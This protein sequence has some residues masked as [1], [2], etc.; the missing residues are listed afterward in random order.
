MG[1]ARVLRGVLGIIELQEDAAPDLDARG[2]ATPCR[3]LLARNFERS[4]DNRT[5]VT[6]RSSVL[7]TIYLCR[8][9][10]DLYGNKV[11]K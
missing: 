2:A 5:F 4:H 7:R 8:V 10:S 3:W 11:C 1:A 6:R 9:I